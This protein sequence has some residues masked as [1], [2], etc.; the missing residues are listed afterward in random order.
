MPP[1][2]SVEDTFRVAIE[3]IRPDGDAQAWIGSPIAI[4]TRKFPFRFGRNKVKEMEHRVSGDGVLL[5]ETLP[6]QVSRNHCVIEYAGEGLVLRDCG[7]T[8]GTVVDGVALHRRRVAF[9]APL[10]VGEHM[11]RLGGPR[12]P[13]W[14]RIVVSRLRKKK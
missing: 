9:T 2:P 3:S 14:F 8:L 5:A 12:S 10:P 1:S 7:S 11:V 4:V 6:Y 13:H